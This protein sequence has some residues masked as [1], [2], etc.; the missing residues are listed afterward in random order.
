M[1]PYCLAKTKA[2]LGRKATFDYF[3]NE[4]FLIDIP[5]RRKQTACWRMR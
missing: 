2:K 1:M 5:E 3:R 4:D